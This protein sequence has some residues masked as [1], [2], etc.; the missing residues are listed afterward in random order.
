ML[1]DELS[2]SETVLPPR[3]LSPVANKSSD[4]SK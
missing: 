1:Q 2:L 3:W 4:V